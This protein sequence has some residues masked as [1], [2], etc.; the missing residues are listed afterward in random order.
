M[1]DA[2]RNK[3]IAEETMDPDWAQLGAR[4]DEHRIDS[5]A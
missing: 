1:S 2:R 5:H 4:E 3:K